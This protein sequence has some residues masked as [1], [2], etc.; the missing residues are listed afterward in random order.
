MKRAALLLVIL[1]S[2]CLA[3]SQS[4]KI[5]WFY[6]AQSPFMG[7]DPTAVALN[8]AFQ[9]YV[10]I[11]VTEGDPSAIGYSVSVRYVDES[12]QMRTQTKLISRSGTGQDWAFFTT[13]KATVQN[14]Q[15]SGVAFR[16][17]VTEIAV[18]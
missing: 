14:I 1:A 7:N 15:A 17:A 5:F 3:Q 16:G 10:A 12:G 9:P 4:P 13:G 8:A 2:A 6:M 11:A 18:N